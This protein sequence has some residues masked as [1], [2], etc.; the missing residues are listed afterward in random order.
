MKQAVLKWTKSSLDG[1]MLKILL[2]SNFNAYVWATTTN[3][4]P[5]I[6][7]I[8]YSEWENYL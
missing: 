3:P 8:N 6:G 5:G 1:A 4:V 2:V 7:F